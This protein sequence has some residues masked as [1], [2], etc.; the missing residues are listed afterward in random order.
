MKKIRSC[1]FAVATIL[2]VFIGLI[3]CG[4]SKT[5]DVRRP[6]VAD[7]FYPADPQKLKLAIQQFLQ[8]SQE[9]PMEKPVAII[10]PH[11]GY[12]YSGQ[13]CADAYRQVMGRQYDVIVVLGVNHTSGAFRGVSIADYGAFHT[14]IGD[15]RVDE[16]IAS[17][18]S[19]KCK[20]CNRDRGVHINEHSIEVQLPFLQ[21]LFPNAKIVPAIVHPPDLDMCVRFGE[22][23]AAVLKNRQALIVI[24]SD[25]S[26]YPNHRDGAKADRLTLTTIA[27]L[28]PSRVSSLM[29]ELDLPNLD[30]RA[31]GEAAILAGITAAKALGATRAVIAGYANSG[32]VPIGE[33]SRTVGYGAVV[34]A[35]GKAPG[36][37]SVLDRAPAPSQ[38]TPLKDSEKKALLAFARESINRY[39]TTQTL[40]LANKFPARME[41]MQGAFVTLKKNGQL[42]GCIGHIP[43]DE[44]L[45]RTVGAMALQAA[46]GDPRFA[47]VQLNEVK[48]LEIEISALTPLKRVG[49]AD[50]I[51]VGRDGVLMSKAGASAVFLPQVAPENNWGRAEMLDNLCMKAG[52]QTGCWKRDAQFQVFQADVFN[53]SQFK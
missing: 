25:L 43:G 40:P 45:G 34:L 8:G 3:A 46:F 42:R 52:L 26:H 27:G 29:K 50:E 14:P 7:K 1:V 20:D 47:P 15:S 31:C 44:E 49:S 12:I 37:T 36:D 19:A 35:P 17:A 24:S 28:D 11:A 33:V 2:A 38:A 30:T 23:L 18:L 21:V 41:F 48:S 9:I 13:I 4:N 5:P 10:V 53:E 51:V 32:D 16:E 39:L 22:A 6:A